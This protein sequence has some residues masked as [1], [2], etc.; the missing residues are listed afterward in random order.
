[1]EL[2]DLV[3]RDPDPRDARSAF[4]TITPRDRSVAKRSRQGHHDFLQHVFGEALDD[5]D[6]SDLARV[7]NRI[8]ASLS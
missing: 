2:S 6:L 7:M 4:A 8:S 5:R 3:R 1:M